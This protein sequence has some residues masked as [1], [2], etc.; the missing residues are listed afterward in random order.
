MTNIP[1]C[2]S[3]W[4]EVALRDQR[5]AT[6]LYLIMAAHRAPAHSDIVPQLFVVARV[7]LRAV[8]SD[9]QATRGAKITGSLA[10]DT[11]PQIL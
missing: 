5:F 4:L 2:S 1:F 11:A 9:A 6:S 7:A 10:R 3:L 8:T